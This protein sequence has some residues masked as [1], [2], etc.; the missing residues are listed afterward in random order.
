MCM[1]P[2]FTFKLYRKMALQLL[3]VTA[4]CTVYACV[5]Q[6][7]QTVHEIRLAKMQQL[8]AISHNKAE[9]GAKQSI[10]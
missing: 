2:E 7:R 3:V 4:F 5:Q 8:K 10:N 9:I 6:A 1:R